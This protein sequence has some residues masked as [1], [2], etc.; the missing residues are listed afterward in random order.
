[1]NGLLFIDTLLCSVA[2]AAAVTRNNSTTKEC[3]QALPIVYSSV[4]CPRK[5][6]PKATNCKTRPTVL[7]SV[8]P[9]ERRPLRLAV[10]STSSAHCLQRRWPTIY[11]SRILWIGGRRR[12]L[13]VWLGGEI[14]QEQLESSPTPFFAPWNL[15]RFSHSVVH[16]SIRS[17][18]LR[19][20]TWLMRGLSRLGLWC[21][22]HTAIHVWVS[23]TKTLETWI[24][25]L[26]SSNPFIAIRGSME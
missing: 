12:M 8:T 22:R 19:H 26:W 7:R 25:G 23:L 4:L 16:P 15:S 3:L 18:R 5:P 11:L 9:T 2:C 1:M 17:E 10:K 6:P 21:D 13:K 24:I 20:K 14:V